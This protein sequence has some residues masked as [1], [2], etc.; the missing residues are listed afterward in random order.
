MGGPILYETELVFHFFKK[1]LFGGDLVSC[2][3]DEDSW[4]FF[5]IVWVSESKIEGVDFATE[6]QDFFF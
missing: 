2:F 5:D 3:L 6:G 1:I 4:G